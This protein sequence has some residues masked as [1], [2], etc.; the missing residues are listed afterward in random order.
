MQL[1]D[2][3]MRF[4]LKLGYPAKS[5]V[6]TAIE[7]GTDGQRRASNVFLILDQA[8][9]QVIGAVLVSQSSDTDSLEA[10]A[11]ALS[12]YSTRFENKIGEYII[13]LGP[14][15]AQTGDVGF[16]EFDGSDGF[17]QINVEA[18]PG[19]NDL[20]LKYKLERGEEKRLAEQRQGRSIG[21]FA[22]VA[23]LLFVLLAGADLYLDKAFGLHYL[24]LQR[25]L[26]LIGAA[27]FLFLPLLVR[28]RR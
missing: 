22:W 16:F 18:F 21:T 2:I 28:R 9:T 14:D 8:G 6:T 27:T 5:V 4:L 19:Y 25:T 17:V 7:T 24:N 13:A 23:A 20:Q 11:S 26:L 10:Q 1:S 3:A 15:A 12:D